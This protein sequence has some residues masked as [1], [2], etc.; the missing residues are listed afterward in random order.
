MTTSLGTTNFK[1]G[2]RLEFHIKDDHVN[3]MLFQN[4]TQ[5]GTLSLN[6]L[7]CQQIV[8]YHTLPYSARIKIDHFISRYIFSPQQEGVFLEAERVSLQS[9]Q[10]SVSQLKIMSTSCP[11]FKLRSSSPDVFSL[12]SGS[13]KV[14]YYNNAGEEDRRAS[15]AGYQRGL[16]NI[17][18]H[19]KGMPI[20]PALKLK[21]SSPDILS[22][23]WEQEKSRSA[24]P[25]LTI[26]E[27]K[28]LL[29]RYQVSESEIK[30][31]TQTVT[32][33][34]LQPL[35][36][37]AL[38][39]QILSL[40]EIPPLALPIF[41]L[42]GSQGYSL[43]H[44][45]IHL[46]QSSKLDP[47]DNLNRKELYF[48]ANRCDS[49]GRTP[50]QLAAFLGDLNAI[51]QL[52][53]CYVDLNHGAD[54]VGGTAVHYA[55]LGEQPDAIKLLDLLGAS[56]TC[57]DSAGLT[58]LA[59]L[60]RKEG[61]FKSVLARLCEALLI[62]LPK[63]SNIQK[64]ALFHLTKQPPL[65]VLRSDSKQENHQ[66]VIQAYE[67]A[68]LIA[69]HMRD[70]K[71][72]GIISYHLGNAYLALNNNQKAIKCYEKYLENTQEEEQEEEFDFNIQSNLIDIFSAYGHFEKAVAVA[73]RVAD[74]YYMNFG[75]IDS[76]INT[77]TKLRT[78][79]SPSV[80]P[81]LNGRL[82]KGIV[83]I[84]EE[85]GEIS[86]ILSFFEKVKKEMGLSASF[87]DMIEKEIAK[88]SHQQYLIENDCIRIPRKLFDQ[89]ET[90]LKSALNDISGNI[91]LKIDPFQFGSILFYYREMQ[92]NELIM[93]QH[94]TDYEEQD[95]KEREKLKM[96]EKIQY[97]PAYRKIKVR[98][99]LS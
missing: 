29:T 20:S 36:I 31:I 79:V 57:K 89:L 60:R 8:S 46:N 66:E 13:E 42:K 39:K 50:L 90:I 1:D 38:F 53:A 69:K 91:F 55:A 28:N 52:H 24:A 97:N 49:Q 17:P 72:E 77:L 27:L 99:D 68:S 7:S 11:A 18:Y 54:R 40:D 75:N 70:I 59:A 32:Y 45:A 84:Y 82:V 14:R 56:L 62:K 51:Q 23:H 9:S 81:E 95:Q 94:Y 85:E 21:S 19:G 86:N 92:N 80:H 10:E 26:E 16:G 83:K 4:D 74:E 37:D 71:T 64:T 25:L 63:M 35:L 76:A 33:A 12:Q 78:S 34:E 88:Y 73:E 58:P 47:S 2:Y 15:L 65:N 5:L 3:A 48:L 93:I 41:K 96:I 67:K 98:F 22:I 61:V 87:K 30:T 6:E 43:L 44:F